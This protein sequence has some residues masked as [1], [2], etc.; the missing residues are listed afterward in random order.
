M[1]VLYNRAME[2]PKAIHSKRS[3]RPDSTRR[4]S[5]PIPHGYQVTSVLLMPDVI[6]WA[7][8]QPEGLSGLVRI[9]LDEEMERRTKKRAKAAQ[10]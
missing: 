1:Y 9:L 6:E 2:T 5:G 4:K 8:V 10:R 3:E 7:K